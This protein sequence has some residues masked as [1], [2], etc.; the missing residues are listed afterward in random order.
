MPTELVIGDRKALLTYEVIGL[1]LARGAGALEIAQQV[2][3]QPST[4]VEIWPLGVEGES[5]QVGGESLVI[6]SRH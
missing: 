5:V 1:A 6:L 2:I 4:R 3:G